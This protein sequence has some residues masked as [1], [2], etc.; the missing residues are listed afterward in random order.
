MG[1]NVKYACM[2]NSV[3]LSYKETQHSQSAILQQNFFKKMQ[4]LI[5]INLKKIKKK[6]S[7]FI[8]NTDI[9]KA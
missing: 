4:V 6:G 2:D 9:Q 7:H 8:N 3:T 1:G 5:K